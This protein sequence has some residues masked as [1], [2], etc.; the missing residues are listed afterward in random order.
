LPSLRPRARLPGR[1]PSRP[2]RPQ[3]LAQLIA[4]ARAACGIERMRRPGPIGPAVLL[5]RTRSRI[6]PKWR[7]Y[8]RFGRSRRYAAATPADVN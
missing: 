4:I 5:A 2:G 6:E 1:L 7:T 8:A 3:V